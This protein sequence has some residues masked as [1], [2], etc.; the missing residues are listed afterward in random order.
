MSQIYTLPSGKQVYDDN[1]QMRDAK[2]GAVISGDANAI[3]TP[4]PSTV[5]MEPTTISSDM[6]SQIGKYQQRID[7]LSGGETL[8]QNKSRVANQGKSG[9]DVFG[10]PTGI[11]GA[12]VLALQEDKRKSGGTYTG[13]DGNEY[14]NYDGSPVSQSSTSS[15]ID[16]HGIPTGDPLQA[17]L[18]QTSRVYDY[19][20]AKSDPQTNALIAQ[21]QQQY[22][23]LINMQKMTNA[24]QQAGVDTALLRGGSSRYSTSGEGISAAQ[25][26]AGALALADL[27]SKEQQAI[28]NVKSAAESKNWDVV[29][30]LLDQAE[31]LR[32]DKISLAKQQSNTLAEQVRKASISQ[33]ISSLIDAQGEKA[34][35]KSI[36]DAMNSNPLYAGLNATA[37]DVQKA[38]ADLVGSPEQL[39]TDWK[40]YQKLLGTGELAKVTGKENPTWFDYQQAKQMASVR[41]TDPVSN[42]ILL[43]TLQEKQLAL[44]GYVS[45][46]TDASGA[47]SQKDVM[48]GD[49]MKQAMGEAAS[50]LRMSKGQEFS[51][52][53]QRGEYTKA[54][55]HILNTALQTEDVESSKKY[56]DS[57]N[58]VRQIKAF[59]DLMHEMQASGVDT[60]FV[61][62][63]V[64]N[65]IRRIGNTTD[66]K[67]VEFQNRAKLILQS[68]RRAMSGVA[69]SAAENEDY[70]SIFPNYKNDISVNDA[71]N[72]SITDSLGM[73]LENFYDRKLG[74]DNYEYIKQMGAQPEYGVNVKMEPEV[75]M[76]LISG[77]GD[78][79]S[80]SD[81]GF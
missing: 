1:G 10:N 37:D 74:H 57:L 3:P 75:D 20:K 19:V 58:V 80:S 65:S 23:T 63:S 4:T 67:L 12:D 28:L 33:S 64:E 6:T 41:P 68:Y 36:L 47:V 69:F 7:T 39:G 13:I 62:G 26:S 55:G 35:P 49:A 56:T 60:G 48:L 79:G 24:G 40:V 71:L 5:K 18:D 52:Y 59:G 16:E 25:M 38:Y 43:V 72:S 30:K 32:Q 8:A 15:G 70:K 81:L 14:Y 42:A 21:I 54:V 29:G 73:Q 9:Y 46:P 78:A 2:T 34:T 27:Q 77:G 22:A 53:L 61:R 50:T 51:D 11:G 76:S 17:T 45:L 66:P 44:R 31:K